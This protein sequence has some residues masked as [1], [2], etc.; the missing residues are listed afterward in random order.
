MHVSRALLVVPLI[1]YDNSAHAPSAALVSM[2]HPQHIT[3]A[4]ESACVHVCIATDVHKG[5]NKSNRIYPVPGGPFQGLGLSPRCDP[6]GSKG[7]CTSI[8]A[9]GQV[10]E[11]K[12]HRSR[13]IGQ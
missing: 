4:V 9:I 12:G 11:V 2:A 1:L 10:L 6:K 5:E 3:Q 7:H 13:V 8:R